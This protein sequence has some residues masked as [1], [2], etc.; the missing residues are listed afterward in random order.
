[1][2]NTR[3]TIV[4]KESRA[5]SHAVF[6]AGILTMLSIFAVDLAAARCRILSAAIARKMT[7]ADLPIGANIGFTTF[8]RAP[9]SVSMALQKADRAMYTVKV[10]RP[11]S[12]MSR[13][14]AQKLQ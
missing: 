3:F 4:A 11:L 14:V 9:D 1:M 10:N 7:L 2:I 8:E 6:L 5:L 12:I 13:M